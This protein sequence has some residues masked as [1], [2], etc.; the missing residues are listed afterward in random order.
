MTCAAS[1]GPTIEQA[2]T[3]AGYPA[4]VLQLMDELTLTLPRRIRNETAAAITAAGG[5]WTPHGDAHKAYRKGHRPRQ[6]GC[7]TL[8]DT[9]KA[10]RCCV[11]AAGME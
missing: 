4:P 10:G 8:F 7:R 3:Q 2:S 1:A 11:Y 9:G 5:T 6:Y